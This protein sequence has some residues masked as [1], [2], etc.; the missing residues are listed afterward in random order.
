MT[1]TAENAHCKHGLRLAWALVAIGGCTS[2]DVAAPP[3]GKTQSSEASAEQVIWQRSPFF[4]DAMSRFS[5]VAAVAGWRVDPESDGVLEDVMLTQLLGPDYGLEESQLVA[6]RFLGAEGAARRTS[7]SA[8][9]FSAAIVPAEATGFGNWLRRE[10]E[11]LDSLEKHIAASFYAGLEREFL[12]LPASTRNEAS[13]MEPLRRWQRSDLPNSLLV[14]DTATH[15]D[16]LVHLFD[17]YRK[18]VRGD[19]QQVAAADED[20]VAL[21]YRVQQVRAAVLAS[22]A[23]QEFETTSARTSERSDEAAKTFLA[24]LSRR[25]ILALCGGVISG[26]THFVDALDRKALENFC[27]A[28]LDLLRPVI[29]VTAATLSDLQP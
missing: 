9:R 25:A 21:I 4:R 16:R 3:D 15:D 24:H 10:H 18:F 13:G 12:K 17:T 6:A 11:L 19:A 2:M 7:E 26:E 22:T 27:T 5:P 29:G 14:M 20:A 23:W 28:S 8:E 1:P